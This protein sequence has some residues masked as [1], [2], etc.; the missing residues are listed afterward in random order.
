MR[1]KPYPRNYD[2]ENAIF[3]VAG[4]K[5]FIH[6]DDLVREVVKILEERGFYTGLV[7]PKRIWRIYEKMVKQGKIY[8]FFLVIRNE[9]YE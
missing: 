7:T 9:D 1:K 2:I 4:N 8:D 5:F 6:P 3:Y